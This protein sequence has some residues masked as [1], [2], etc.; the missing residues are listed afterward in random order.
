[1]QGVWG[2][3]ENKLKLGK[4]D[5]ENKLNLAKPD[6]RPLDIRPLVGLVPH[7]YDW[8]AVA[9]G[10][11]CR[12]ICSVCTCRRMLVRPLIYM[13]GWSNFPATVLVLHSAISVI[14]G[15]TTTSKWRVLT[16]WEP[17]L[18]VRWREHTPPWCCRRFST[19]EKDQVLQ[20]SQKRIKVT[21]ELAIQYLPRDPSVD[22]N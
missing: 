2:G 15:V 16:R 6:I 10:N 4:Q 19:D 20:K 13:D 14:V 18:G 21:H 5:S 8:P 9:R 7:T 17:R 1:M 12:P 22:T 3:T 11:A